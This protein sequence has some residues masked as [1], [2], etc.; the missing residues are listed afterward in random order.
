MNTSEKQKQGKSSRDKGARFERELVGILRD[1]YGYPVRR[2]YVYYKEP[3]L[4]GLDGIHIE[5]KAVENLNIRKAYKQ[6]VEDAEKHADGLPVV[7]HHKNRQGWLVTLSLADF[8]D[9]YGGWHDD[10]KGNGSEA[11]GGL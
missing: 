6:A 11:S 5:C 1:F 8:M 10:T 3:D 2:G 9:M 4:I 7:F